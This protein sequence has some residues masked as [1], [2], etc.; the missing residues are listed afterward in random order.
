MGPRRLLAEAGEFLGVEGMD[1]VMDGAPG[2]AQVLG[3]L[4]RPQAVV[5][6]QEDLAPTY[7]EGIGG[8][9]AG[10]ELMPLGGGQ[11][12]NKKWWLHTS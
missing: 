4:G 6:G 12:A 11:G 9:Q 2:T 5:A 8:S 1:G 7:R 10:L 3:D